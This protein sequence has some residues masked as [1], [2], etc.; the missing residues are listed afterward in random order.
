MSR[1]FTPLGVDE[2]PNEGNLVGLDAEFV[3]LNQVGSMTY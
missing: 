3:T 1:E 2:L